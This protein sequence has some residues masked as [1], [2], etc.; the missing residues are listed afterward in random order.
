MLVTAGMTALL[1][2]CVHA[3]VQGLA[4]ARPELFDRSGRVQPGAYGAAYSPDGTRLAVKSGLGIGA[5]TSGGKVRLVTPP[6]SHAVDFAW[7]PTGG[8][9][10]IAEGPA[11]TGQLDVLRLDGV[12]RG[13]VP[14]DPVFSVGSGYGMAVSPDGHQAVA[15]AE[16]VA[17]LGGP[18]RLSL[19]RIDLGTGKVSMVGVD[20]VRGPTYID[21]DHVLVTAL[22]AS[23]D[24]T[25]VITLS[26][27][28]RRPIS[29]PGEPA[30]ALGPVLAGRW[31]VYA[32]ERSVWAVP[33]TG[34]D[35]VR[36]ATLPKGATAVAVD[37][38]GGQA[39][40]G[41]RNGDV[42]QL[43]ALRLRG[44]PVRR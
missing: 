27:A 1:A 33:A 10:L 13:R 40:I 16:D 39:L 26:T 37:P 41:Q 3:P 34:G 17:A 4:P 2:G 38:E 31:L 9:L 25:E 15:L 12:S 5:V 6:G 22:A 32:T 19:V 14:L 28:Q 18:E 11:A 36:L 21:I 35:R 20:A 29:P 43:R 8:D 23:G 24:R 42:E 30:D 44:L 7:M